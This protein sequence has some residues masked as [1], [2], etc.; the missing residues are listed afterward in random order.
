[1][2]PVGHEERFPLTRLSV[3][4]GFRKETIAG[5]RRNGRDAPIP[6]V[7]ADRCGANALGRKRSSANAT[8]ILS[9][10]NLWWPVSITV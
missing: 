10:D 1:M 7:R 2:T 8:P 3:G 6:A 9:I 5:M 4:C